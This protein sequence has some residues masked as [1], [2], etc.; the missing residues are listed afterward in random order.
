MWLRISLL[1]EISS[2]GNFL[3][4][5]LLIE[6]L[7]FR[8]WGFVREIFHWDCET[9]FI[10]GRIGSFFLNRVFLLCVE[11]LAIRVFEWMIVRCEFDILRGILMWEKTRQFK[12][13]L[14]LF[15]QA[16]WVRYIHILSITQ[17]VEIEGRLIISITKVVVDE[18]VALRLDFRLLSNPIELNNFAFIIACIDAESHFALLK[19]KVWRVDCI[20][21]L[22]MKVEVVEI[23]QWRWSFS[24]FVAVCRVWVSETLL[25]GCVVWVD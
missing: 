10:K 19:G 3:L 18:T 22:I 23:K 16:I 14:L 12:H 21:I 11:S 15:Y 9:I 1:V 4:A 6:A 5:D 25:A 17:D 8:W 2:G 20:N 13:H 24:K 7:F